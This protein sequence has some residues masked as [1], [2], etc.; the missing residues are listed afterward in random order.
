LSRG[1]DWLGP[2]V[3]RLLVASCRNL[4]RLTAS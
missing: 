1:C 3:T 4:L 2:A